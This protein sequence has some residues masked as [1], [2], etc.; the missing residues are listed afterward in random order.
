[1]SVLQLAPTASLQVTDRLSI[2]FAP[3]IT[4]AEAALDPNFL[5]SPNFVPPG[6]PVYP[7]ATHTRLHWGLGFQVGMYYEMDCGWRFGASYKSPQ[8]FE[9]FT[10]YTTTPTGAPRTDR[11]AMDYPG[12]I[13]LGTSYCGI[14]GVVWALDVRY[15]DYD[16]AQLFGHGAQFDQTG[17]LGGLG[18]QSVFAVST[19]VQYQ[20]T[21]A[22]S[23]R[24]GYLYNQNPID[25][26]DSFANSASPAI[27]QHIISMGATWQLTCR[28]GLSIA[29]LRAFEN[30]IQGPG[31]APGTT[32]GSSVAVN[33]LVAGLQV[34][35]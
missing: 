22:I 25:D 28:T 12:I 19:G 1:L 30:E 18:W 24:L 4:M 8:W 5:A 31:P 6:I 14:P 32:V 26:A 29:Y 11:L 7:A 9:E 16:N 15:I 13:S 35:F 21:N 33:A 20:L 3:T 17:A 10:Y 27:Y 34:K 2:G 23:L